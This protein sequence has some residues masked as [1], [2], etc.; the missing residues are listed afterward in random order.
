MGDLLTT[1]SPL[2]SS[3]DSLLGGGSAHRMDALEMKLDQILAALSASSATTAVAV[4]EI[5][6]V[7]GGAMDS[8]EGSHRVL[9]EE[10]TPYQ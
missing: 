9:I 2:S 4:P 6:V 3:D 10:A 1:S 7:E 5:I 8:P